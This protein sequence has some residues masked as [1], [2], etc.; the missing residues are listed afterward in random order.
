V[1]VCRSGYRSLLAA[2]NMKLMGYEKVVSLKTGLRG[3]KDFEQPLVDADG[4][5]VDLD[6]ADEYFTARLR[7]EQR[8]P[9]A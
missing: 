1:L 8:R 6:D 2:A 5:S 7:P 3:W 9:A 4:G